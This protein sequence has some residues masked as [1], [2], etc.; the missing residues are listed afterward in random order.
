MTLKC[1]KDV[2]E[3]VRMS[4]RKVQ[5]YSELHHFDYFFPQILKMSPKFKNRPLHPKE[6]ASP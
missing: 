6:A 2:M 1:A 5:S 3:N 4:E